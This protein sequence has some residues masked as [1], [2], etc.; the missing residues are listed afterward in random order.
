MR[1]HQEK[2]WI[3]SI[4][5]RFIH[6]FIHSIHCPGNSVHAST[7]KPLYN[8][9]VLRHDWKV[10]RCTSF[11]LQLARIHS[12]HCNSIIMIAVANETTILQG[13]GNRSDFSSDSSSMFVMESVEYISTNWKSILCVGICN[14]VTGTGCLLFPVFAT[15]IAEI[16]VTSLVFV[17]GLLIV[18]T[19]CATSST[20]SSDPAQQSPLFWAG[21]G[22]ILLAVVM[23]SNPLLT[24][25]LF[26][27][28]IAMTFVLLGSIQIYMARQ[29]P[30]RV[31]GRA[32]MI[33]SGASAILMS[34]IICL[35]MP[36]ARW[37]TIGVLM[38]VNLVNIGFNRIIIGLYGRKLAASHDDTESWRSV[39]DADLL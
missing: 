6:S 1:A 28:L 35:S 18:L 27:F 37:F 20:R 10:R 25:T 14:I 29:Y 17:S 5:I 38:G 36:T 12:V 30:E 3:D 9:I 26:T 11:F 32:L 23:Y 16:M 39:L 21:M 34:F 31:A 22:Q 15:Q 2:N 7:I 19:S 24:L 13:D 33:I 8:T 4:L